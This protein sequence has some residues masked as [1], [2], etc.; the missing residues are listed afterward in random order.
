MAGGF[1]L[2]GDNN[3]AMSIVRSIEDIGHRAKAMSEVAHAIGHRGNI[4]AAT[5]LFSL[6]FQETQRL[7]GD[8]NRFRVIQHMVHR[9]TKLGRHADAFKMAGH[10]RDRQ[11]QALTMLEMVQELSLIHI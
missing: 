5:S 7:A 4:D 8:E 6:V 3:S 9:Q 10:I 2:A 11:M 1:V